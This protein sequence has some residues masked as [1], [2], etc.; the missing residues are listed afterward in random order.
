MKNNRFIAKLLTALLPLS[1]GSI[2]Q[3][4]ELQAGMNALLGPLR[5]IERFIADEDAFSD[6]AN[7]SDIARNLQQLRSNFHTIEMIPSRFHNL[8]GFALALQQVSDI[9]DDSTRRF[10]EGKV[11]YAWWRLRSLPGNCFACHATYKVSSTISASDAV[12]PSLDPMQQARFLLAT[13]Q[14][15]A[16]KEKL[17]TVLQ[18]PEYRF[19]FDEALRSLL[20]IQT[21]IEKDPAGAIALFQGILSTSKL[22]EEDVHEVRLWLESLKKWK[23]SSTSTK[24]ALTEGEKLILTGSTKGLDLLRDDVSLLRGTALL[25]SALESGTLKPVDRSKA[26]YLLGFAYEQ[27]PL[28]FAESWTEMYLEQCIQ[29]FPGSTD[30]K[31]A[32]RV[33]RQHIIADFTGSGGTDIPDEVSIHLDELRKKAYG[34][35]TFNGKV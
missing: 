29:E 16:A 3:A 26:L 2:G 8:D 30:A 19:F 28:F 17:S 6:P 13:R 24:N 7:Q 12:D 1:S 18:N 10:N 21:R 32:F 25:H 5:S 23:S 22:P 11:S 34:E 31:N 20:L 33:Y 27:L 9:L 15:P 14:F 4:E 35:P